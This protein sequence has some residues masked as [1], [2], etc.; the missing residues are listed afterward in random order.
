MT[1]QTILLLI[2]I[3]LVAG[4]LSGFIGIGG[5]VVMVPAL[6]YVLQM[7]QHSAQGTSLILMLPP[8]GI[9][10]VMNYWKAGKLNWEY[11]AI[12]AIAFVIGGYF[13]SKLTLKLSPSLVKIIFGLLMLYISFKMI[14]SGYKEGGLK[15][16]IYKDEGTDTAEIE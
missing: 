16:G 14:H 13:G 5:G 7:D 1:F 9:L 8:I 3:G 4:T 10:A 6:V 2:L 12:I 11:G 15:K